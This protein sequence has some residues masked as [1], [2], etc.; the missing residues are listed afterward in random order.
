MFINSDDI[1]CSYGGQSLST[2]NV[3]DEWIN[4][5]Y[6]ISRLSDEEEGAA[7]DKKLIKIYINGVMSACVECGS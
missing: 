4:C 5:T 3:E 2:Y 1:Q 7:S 6:V